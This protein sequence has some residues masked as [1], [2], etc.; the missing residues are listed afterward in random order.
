MPK[1]K[2]TRP[3]RGQPPKSDKLKRIHFSALESEIEYIGGIDEAKKLMRS[4]WALY[5]KTNQKQIQWQKKT[6]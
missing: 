3:T 4:F 2:Q 6:K 1:E 5:V